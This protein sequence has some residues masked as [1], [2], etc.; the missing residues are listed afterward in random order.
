MIKYDIVEKWRINQEKA[1]DSVK[2]NMEVPVHKVAILVRGAVG[3]RGNSRPTMKGRENRKCTQSEK[4]PSKLPD[5]P[6][7]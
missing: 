7:R 1:P 3:L 2:R 4:Q 5:V 6:R